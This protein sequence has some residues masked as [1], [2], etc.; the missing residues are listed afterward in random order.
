[1]HLFLWLHV[2]L[3]VN[4]TFLWKHCSGQAQ[5][6]FELLED[7]QSLRLKSI[8]VVQALV[9]QLSSSTK[10][11]P[12]A[13]DRDTSKL[14]KIFGSS[15]DPRYHS[16]SKP[17]DLNLTYSEKII[18]KQLKENMPESLTKED[19]SLTGV[20]ANLKLHSRA[21]YYFQLYLQLKSFC[22]I[23][24]QWLDLGETFWPRYFKETFCIPK[25]CSYPSGMKCGHDR[26]EMH[27]VSLLYWNCHARVKK[28][29][30]TQCGW[31]SI[32][33]KVDKKCVCS[34]GAS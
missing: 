4:E 34:C 12:A 27:P 26:N 14:L 11:K 10:T 15:F 17:R 28:S 9:E 31:S 18:E 3:I 25:P 30:A 5:L 2:I 33:I 32:N 21:K 29:G 16:I 24:Y 7:K 8:T 1:M 6:F 19:F 20:D 23:S 22:P 13:E